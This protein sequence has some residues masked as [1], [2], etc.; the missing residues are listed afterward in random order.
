MPRKSVKTDSTSA[1]SQ[2]APDQTPESTAETTPAPKR[3]RAKATDPTA[4]ESSKTESTKPPAKVLRSRRLVKKVLGRDVAAT[5]A[6]GV[7]P[8]PVEEARVET[9]PVETSP[10]VTS[11]VEASLTKTSRRTAKAKTTASPA[12]ESTPAPSGRPATAKASGR[13]KAVTES[14]TETPTPVAAI[15]LGEIVVPPKRKTKKTAE[16]APVS[17]T[18]NDLDLSEFAD[19][20]LPEVTFRT[21]QSRRSSDVKAAPGGTD[22]TDKPSKADRS[23]SENRPKKKLFGREIKGESSVPVAAAPAPTDPTESEPI[24]YD[25]EDGEIG[26]TV[27]A[28]RGTGSRP[29]ASPSSSPSASSTAGDE[30]Q[31]ASRGRNRRRRGRRD[32]DAT[33]ETIARDELE[34]ESGDEPLVSVLPVAP[35][36]PEPIRSVP[37]PADA[38]QVIL[39]N[40]IPTLINRKRVIPALFFH[41][42]WRTDRSATVARE[43]LRL[44]AENGVHQFSF[45][46]DLEVDGAGADAVLE[47]AARILTE[48]VTLDPQ[49]NVL[50]RLRFTASPSWRD[51][52][53]NA[54]YRALDGTPAPP[55]IGDDGFWDQANRQLRRLVEGLRSLPQADSVLGLHLDRNEWYLPANFGY[56]NS[57]AAEAKFR[58]WTRTRY[59]QDEVALR[60][61]WFDGGIRFDTVEVPDY[62]PD[63]A[64]GERFVRSSRKQRRYV[65]YHLFLSDAMV[66]R[67]GD[68]ARTAKEASEGRFLVGTSY[69]Y[70][71]EWYHPSSGH[72]AL[73]KLLRT[74]EIDYIAG[75]P[76][77]RTREPGGTGGFPSP[78]DSIAINGK[79]FISEEDFRTSL[80]DGR[81]DDEWNPVMKSPQALE[82]VHWRGAGAA[83]A[84]GSGL[85]WM[86]SHGTGWLKTPGVWDRA[87]QVQEALLRRQ[88][89]VLADP[90]VAV[91][92]D[93]RSLAYLV[94]PN[95]FEMLVQN[96]QESVLRAGVSANFYL[97]SDLAHREQF[98]DSK[99]YIFLNAW[100]IRPELRAAI[101]SR[102]QR[103]NKVLFWLYAAGLFESGR[104]AIERVREVTGI[105]IKP[106]PFHS[107]P[108][109]TIV[110]RRHALADVFPEKTLIASTALEP[111]YFA[112]PEGAT[113]LGEYTQTGL[114]S[115]VI[116]HFSDGPDAKWT[117]VFLGEPVV[118]AALIRALAQE[119]GAHVFDFTEDVVHVRHPFLVIH[120]KGTGP[121]VI[122]LP[123][124]HA[125]YDLLARQWISIDSPNIR[126]QA[127]DGNTYVFLTG[128]QTE[129]EHFLRT[130]P[131]ANLDL[132]EIPE[133]EANIR[134]DLSNFDVPIMR[135]GEWVGNQDSDDASDDWLLRP[136]PTL[137]EFQANTPEE[138]APQASTSGRRRRTRRGRDRDRDQRSGS[139]APPV[140][141]ITTG[142]TADEESGMNIVFRRR[143]S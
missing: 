77:Y 25:T 73:G 22:R 29:S 82:S 54:Y 121:R 37:I 17:A 56:D 95:A 72:L 32:E 115:F 118:N 41:T 125:A 102:L 97:L 141:G 31:D 16:I 107:R 67:I 68:L 30:D 106:Q 13:K 136:Q 28:W 91:F 104:D 26:L 9:S 129:I 60:A 128:P 90:D 76:S 80:G 89:A 113:V 84:H 66:R 101:K 7:E 57:R 58:E 43:E 134:H 81:D 50:F 4:A 116:K 39:R 139:S 11:P 14:T 63:G 108:G 87:K 34:A 96:V 132:A 23:V 103:D 44:A 65:D 120:C 74:E 119:A 127:I 86:D 85:N 143:D 78:I 99:L 69:G 18:T 45:T 61:A 138:D 111:S 36:A 137:E 112:I 70:T 47:E 27:L 75:P 122:P 131:F 64:E 79:L 130:D 8:T 62:L 100:D 10:V 49:A 98:P 46:V 114:P 105:A 135:L 110:N 1:T 15:G 21:S 51:R 19:G 48:V 40:G 55:S 38:P 88:S 123:D 53:P 52:F 5:T 42:R 20:L 124:K 133:R 6:T 2:L 93:E 12:S 109:T 24:Q 83:V 71:F 142:S 140:A 35:P 117:S 94:D 126:Y 92:I 3:S 33:V 59:N